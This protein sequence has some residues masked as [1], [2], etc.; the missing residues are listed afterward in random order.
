MMGPATTPLT[1]PAPTP[2]PASDELDARYRAYR[3]RQAARLLQLMPREAVRPLYRRALAARPDAEGPFQGDSLALLTDFCE[4]LLPLPTREAWARDLEAHPEA[5]LRDLAE[6]VHGP[7]ADAPATLETRTLESGG[8]AW[9]VL[10][11]GFHEP[12]GWRGFLAFRRSGADASFRTATVFQEAH[13]LG[14]RDRF[15]SF[16]PAA[17]EAFLRSAR[18]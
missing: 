5:Y 1:A 3:R 7:T 16:E 18:P 2:T 11:R 6:T 13:P 10:L 9:E 12:S 15:R 8:E 4:G 17:L 14:L